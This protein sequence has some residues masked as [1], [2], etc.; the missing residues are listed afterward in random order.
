[1]SILLS[2]DLSSKTGW[3]CFEDNKLVSYG[4][5]E[6]PV[7]DFSINGHVEQTPNYPFN[8]IACAN[9]ISDEVAKQCYSLNPGVVVIENTVKGRNRHSQR[10]LRMDTLVSVE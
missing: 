5:I 3:A 8:L 4:L 9:E 6:C 1:M 2:L 10:L 7:K